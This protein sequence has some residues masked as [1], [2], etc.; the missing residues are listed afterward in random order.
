MI[1]KTLNRY[2]ASRVI[3]GVLVA[4][5]VV[6]GIIMLVDFVESSRNLDSDSQISS[7]NLLYLTLLK[8]PKLIEQTIPFIVLFGVM[9]A[10]Y[11]M[12]RRSEL[13]VMRAAGLPAWK[14]LRPALW[15]TGLLGVLWATVLNP[16]ATQLTDK[17]DGLQ[18]LWGNSI[19]LNDTQQVWLRDG[20]ENQQTV[21]FA[22]SLKITEKTLSSATF[23]ILSINPDGTTEFERRFDAQSAILITE[24]YWQ[25]NDVI[26]NAPS[27][28]TQ[29]HSAISLPTG[30]SLDDLTKQATQI[31]NPSFWHIPAAIA[32]NQSAGFSSRRLRMQ[33]NKLLALPVTLI[34]MT[35]IAASVSMQLTRE[36]GSLR[37]LITGSAV[38]F[39]VYFA[40]NV[41]SAFGEVAILP[42]LLASWTVPLLILFFGIS[43]L[44]RIEDG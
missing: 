15:V 25:L 23:Y 21:I 4:F 17:H 39:G 32:A 27:E 8:S 18:Q 42:V 36:G 13:I 26:E 41:I 24:G 12:N 35:F 2:I 37:L 14:F 10:L 11:A 33:F 44:A 28:A 29:R 6:T 19:R 22:K 3:K 30:I 38:G 5:L 40:D 20:N 31:S 34:A 16:L 43:Y 9:G 7:L 1:G